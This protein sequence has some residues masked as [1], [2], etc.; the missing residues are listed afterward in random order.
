VIEGQKAIAKRLGV[1]PEKLEETENTLM[2]KG[3]AQNLLMIQSSLRTRVK[4]NI[5]DLENHLPQKKKQLLI[6]L[7]KS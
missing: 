2:E 5:Y 4:Y 7:R 6:K 3:L 1:T